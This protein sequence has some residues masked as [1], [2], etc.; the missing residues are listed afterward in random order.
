MRP[1][2]TP[3]NANHFGLSLDKRIAGA[4]GLPS[5][6]HLRSHPRSAAQ[7]HNQKVLLANIAALAGVGPADPALCDL[8]LCYEEVGTRT[9]LPISDITTNQ[10]VLL[11]A[12][13]CVDP[14]KFEHLPN[15]AFIEV[16][17]HISRSTTMPIKSDITTK[18]P[19]V[20]G[21]TETC[22]Q[23]VLL[24]NIA[25]LATKAPV[26]FD[27]AE[28]CSEDLQGAGS[29]RPR[30][31]VYHNQRVLLAAIRGVNPDKFVHVRPLPPLPPLQAAKEEGGCS[32]M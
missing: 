8:P 31:C 23:R 19:L 20:K 26:S 29:H 22:N 28:A 10:A 5:P 18:P 11:A 27:A 13:R 21:C 25:A 6:E 12:I 1:K 30:G 16:P 17:G 2:F 24:T 14:S 7:C 15:G 9:A 4:P 3:R 32:I